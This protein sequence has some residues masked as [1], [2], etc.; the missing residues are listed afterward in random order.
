L[1]D[2]ATLALSATAGTGTWTNTVKYASIK[3]ARLRVA[4]ALLAT[5]TVTV[6]RV[7]SSSGYTDTVW[8]AVCSGSVASFSPT[9]YWGLKYGDTLVCASG[10]GTGATVREQWD[11]ALKE[12]GYADA[13]RRFPELAAAYRKQYATNAKAG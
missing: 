7:I 2:Y 11:A 8:T 5:D 1:I 6:T 9:N 10:T 12:H 13:A 3:I 4:R